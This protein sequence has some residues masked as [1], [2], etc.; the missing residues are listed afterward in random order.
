MEQSLIDGGELMKSGRLLLV[1]KLTSEM[2]KKNNYKLAN[3]AL[4]ITRQT[5]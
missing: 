5:I 2:K 4:K 1:H 3:K